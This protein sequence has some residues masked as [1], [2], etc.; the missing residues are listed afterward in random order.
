MASG[1]KERQDQEAQGL[2]GGEGAE[3]AREVGVDVA[4]RQRRERSEVCQCALETREGSTRSHRAILDACTS[5]EC[6]DRN[7]LQMDKYRCSL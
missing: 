5:P 4:H 3:R 2:E 6:K 1:R 7:V